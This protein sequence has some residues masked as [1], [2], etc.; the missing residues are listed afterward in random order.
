[1]RKRRATSHTY[2]HAH[3]HSHTYKNLKEERP[4][5]MNEMLC[6]FSTNCFF[7]RMFHVD[8][9]YSLV[10]VCCFVLKCASAVVE[11]AGCIHTAESPA[12]ANTRCPFVAVSFFLSFLCSEYR[13]P[14]TYSRPKRLSRTV[15]RL[16]L[17]GCGEHRES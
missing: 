16:L 17:Q 12:T 3:P 4:G 2:T 8:A 15:A 11:P 7:P 5:D 9:V 1:M 10:T 13:D 14:T 6:S